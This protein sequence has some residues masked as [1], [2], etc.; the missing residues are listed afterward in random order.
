MPVLNVRD[1]SQ[2]AREYISIQERLKVKR[3]KGNPYSVGAIV[4]MPPLDVYYFT[5]FNGI[6]PG[7]IPGYQAS[8]A[9]GSDAQ[10]VEYSPS[11][12]R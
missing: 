1:D 12:T 2:E 8:T 10:G 6:L 4:Q 3:Q 7:T 9:G 5:G 11:Y